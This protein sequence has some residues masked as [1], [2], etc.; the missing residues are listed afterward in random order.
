MGTGHQG[1]AV[2]FAQ[3]DGGGSGGGIVEINYFGGAF[4]QDGAIDFA[5]FPLFIFG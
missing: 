1:N 3:D 5:Q 4:F 2:R